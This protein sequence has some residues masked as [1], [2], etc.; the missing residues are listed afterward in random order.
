MMSN[1]T[2]QPSVLFR[3]VVILFLSAG[4]VGQTVPV[5]A[6]GVL[7]WY[8]APAPAGADGPACGSAA[9][10]PCASIGYVLANKSNEGDTIQLA[11]GT[12][13]EHD[14][15][16]NK[17]QTIT[18]PVVANGAM[19]TAIIDAGAQG[20]V[21]N[22]IPTLQNSMV[23]LQYIVIQNGSVTSN[24]G[25][26]GGGVFCSFAY[27]LTLMNTVVQNNSAYGT[28]D[29][30][31]GNTRGGGI[32]SGNCNVNISNSLVQGNHSDGWGGGVFSSGT[33]SISNSTIKNNTA[34]KN[35]GGGLAVGA[36]SGAI[37]LSDITVSGNTANYGGGIFSNV[38]HSGTFTLN[39]S[40]V[41]ANQANTGAGIHLYGNMNLTNSTISGNQASLFGGGFYLAGGPTFANLF[42]N[43]VTL[44]G[45]SAMNGN[46]VYAGTGGSTSIVTA[47][48]TIFASSASGQACYAESGTF[49]LSSGGYNLDSDNTC[50]LSSGS[51]DLPGTNPLLG[52]LQDN[53]GWTHT[54]ALLSGSP[55]LNQG[56]PV[57]TL[58]TDQRSQPRNGAPDIGAFEVIQPAELSFTTQVVNFQVGQTTPLYIFLNNPNGAPSILSSLAFTLQLSPG[59]RVAAGQ[60]PQPAD[61]GGTLTAV[62][63]SSQIAFSGG[64]ID[65]EQNPYANCYMVVNVEATAVG[66]ATVSSLGAS[67][68]EAETSP[69]TPLSVPVDGAK[70]F[71]PMV[72]R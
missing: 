35:A 15:L 24:M 67:A 46:D 41:N 1:V 63:G 69:V 13:P 50:H 53:G 54:M 27:S 7:T 32:Y 29:G 12:Y 21:L 72:R 25:A 68:K 48:N 6:G 64:K 18:G 26:N 55:A 14:L 30:S 33:L 62:P 11:A 44:A 17:A 56:N 28:D 8:V 42:T 47:R 39:G 16:I 23:T 9:A 37:Y 34:A 2:S 38:G 10:T 51:H 66:T 61:C 3:L 22:I 52:P 20:R 65:L 58:T 19:P 36:G 5:S 40:T 43:H 59:L 45:N 60:G 71:I 70:V 31:R 4:L 57:V 49:P